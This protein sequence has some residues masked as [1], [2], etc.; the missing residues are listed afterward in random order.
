MWII[1]NTS[2]NTLAESLD[3]ILPSCSN[4][5]IL[6]GYFFFSGYQEMYEHLKDKKVRILVWLEVDTKVLWTISKMTEED[7]ALLPS[8][9]E[10]IGLTWTAKKSYYDMFA[11]IFNKTDIFDNDRIYIAFESFLE[12]I[13]NGTLEIKKTK[14][15]NHAKFYLLHFKEEATLWWTTP[16]FVIEGSSNLTFNG[17]K[18][19]WEHNRILKEPHYYNEDKKKFNELWELSNNI[20]IADTN[21]YE[22]FSTEIKKKLWLYALPKP[23]FVYLR[24]LFEYFSIDESSEKILTPSKLTWGKFSDFKY[25]VDAIQFWVD[26]I[27]KFWWVIVADVVGLWKSIIAS[28][29]AKNLDIKT[30]VIAPPH[31]REQW[32]DY[33]FDFWFNALFYTTGEVEKALERHKDEEKEMLIILD[34]AHKHR[35]EETENYKYLHRLCAGNK[36]LALSA[37]PFNNDPKDIYAIIKLFDT[38]WQSIIRTV[39]NLSMEFRSLIDT[40]KK[41]RRDLRG[42]KGKTPD[43]QKIQEKAQ[44]IANK[45]RYM[46]APIVIRRSRL[47]IER[48]PD[49]KNDLTLQWVSFSKV[50]PPEL[51]EYDLKEVFDVYTE[52]L[53]KISPFEKLEW[54]D[55]FEWARYKTVSYIQPWSSWEKKIQEEYDITNLWETQKQ[56]AKIMRRLLVRRFESSV[57]SF[58]STLKKM[59][60]N[61]EAMLKWYKDEKKV[62]IMKKSW[63]IDPD[64]MEEMTEE[65]IEEHLKE[66]EEKG[67]MFIPASEISPHF[68]EVLVKDIEILQEIYDNWFKA[69]GTCL[70]PDYKFEFFIYKI[71]ESLKKE[72]SRK[73]VVFT[74]FSDTA[75]Y[76]YEKCKNKWVRVFKYSS[77]DAGKENKEVIRKNFDA[78]Y[79]T[80]EDNFDL[81]IATDAIS[82]WFNLH[83]AGTI[84]N[85]DIPYNPTR[86]IQRIGRINRINKKMFEELYIYNFFPTA[87]GEKETKTKAIATLKM[88]LI[89]AL[90]W[91]DTQIFTSEEELRSY[92]ADKYN[93]AEKE[94]ESES[95]DAKYRAVYNSMKS[96]ENLLESVTKIPYR[97][98]IWRNSDWKNW[99]VAFWKRWASYIFAHSLWENEVAYISPEQ[100][101]WLFSSEDIE[102]ALETNTNFYPIYQKVKAHLF[103]KNTNPTVKWRRQDVSILLELLSDLHQEAVEYCSAIKKI[104]DELDALPEGVLKELSQIKLDK[105]N[106]AN[107]F[108]RV[109]EIV[110]ET[111]IEDLLALWEKNKGDEEYILLTEQFL[112]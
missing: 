15:P 88:N 24:V 64:E 99:V 83:R 52:T 100:W 103:K 47:D 73:I 40:Y 30:I 42:K 27:N 7:I 63:L 2:W 58:R 107:I 12:K 48:I 22:E 35:N 92:F 65:E 102:E 61:S 23:Y 51:L 25:Q 55:V 5:D 109:K 72:P 71:Q 3:K 77:Q 62:P 29:I 70:Y 26:R 98:R 60:E 45:L 68:W 94:N 81:L 75:N 49:Y 6:V 9:K 85:Y 69:D 10:S 82:E 112:W 101:L 53:E 95:W 57:D 31:L 78:G 79:K 91:G 59:I 110:P 8:K 54:E 97:S 90:L 86:V 11:N 20:T 44:E 56:I 13:K 36:I 38:P 50:N 14:D 106:L 67:A 105:S 28:A 66:L 74:E 93:E 76:L 80:Q 33:K 37:T 16:W 46:I 43:E 108:A 19:Q 41:L 89:H 1:D 34:E 111:Y 39:E 4:V 96:N 32:E 18:W 104:I 21:T 17:L 84:I 87:T